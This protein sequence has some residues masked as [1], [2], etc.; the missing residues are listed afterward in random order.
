M[1]E[2]LSFRGRPVRESKRNG[3]KVRYVADQLV[4]KLK[5]R[6]LNDSKAQRKVVEVLPRKSNLARGFDE[7]GMAIINLPKS[8]DLFQVAR[9]LEK[10]DEVQFAEPNF[11]DSGS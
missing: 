11:V 7:T 5:S 10:Q 8:A 3:R 4:V 6:F 1:S 9:K 2:A